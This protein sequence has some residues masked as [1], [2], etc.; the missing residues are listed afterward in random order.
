MLSVRHDLPSAE[1]A[2]LE[3]AARPSKRPVLETIGRQTFFIYTC[4]SSTPR[5]ARRVK[6]FTF[7]RLLS[8]RAQPAPAPSGLLDRPL[9]HYTRTGSSLAPSGASPWASPRRSTRNPPDC[10]RHSAA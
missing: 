8:P 7:R 1:G 5:F 9:R 2:L 10:L 4:N 3:T 6:S